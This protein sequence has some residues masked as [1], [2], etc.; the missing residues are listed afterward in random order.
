MKV[1]LKGNEPAQC[2]LWLPFV[3]A[4]LKV[5][6]LINSL[7]QIK[8]GISAERVEALGRRTSNPQLKLSF[9]VDKSL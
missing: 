1:A 3:K 2:Q 6:F 4:E 8:K 7:P 5:L 9:F